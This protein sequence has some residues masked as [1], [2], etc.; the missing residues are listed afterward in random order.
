MPAPAIEPVRRAFQV[1]EAL[2][3]RHRSTLSLLVD[4]TGLPRPTVV[5]LLQTLV[6]LGYA[7][8]VSRQDGY[9][10]TDR[11]LGLAGSIRFVDHLVDAAIPH[12]SGFTAQHGWPLYLATLSDGALT[13]RH[14]TAPES[15]MAFEA[16]ALNT[17]RSILTSALG[18]A[19]LA[20]CTDEQREIQWRALLPAGAAGRR[21]QLALERV[22]ADVRLQGWA[23]TASARPSR[24]HGMAVPVLGRDG[25]LL[26]S[27]SM[28]FP[29]SAMSEPEA[30]ERF[31][32]RLAA[33]ARAIA[34]DTAGRAPGRRSI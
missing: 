22:L 33:V 27:L 18:R 7:Q 1:L 9:R 20:F 34:A 25:R 28:R 24:I 15:P 21:Q 8:R 32:K 16:A 19:W 5:R 31:G 10:L 3:R 14:S 17:R 11:V 23:F 26:G 2:S 30:A 12:M 29:R 6:A 4:E 13:I